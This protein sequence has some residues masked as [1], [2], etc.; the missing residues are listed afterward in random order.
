MI[1]DLDR[2]VEA[3]YAGRVVIVPTDTVYGIAARVDMP[4]AIDRIFEIKGRERAKALP[5]LGASRTQLDEVA[6]LDDRA[7]KLT[8]RYWP[9]A[10][11]L[12]LPRA[13]GF[14]TDLGGDGKTVAVRVPASETTRSLLE[15]S[16][17]LAVTSANRSGEPAAVTAED[18]RRALGDSVDV[19]LDTG[20]SAGTASTVVS[21]IAAPRL[22]RAGTVAW[23]DV[24]MTLEE[25]A[26][27]PGASP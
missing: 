19:F 5:V 15:R 14:T 4:G 12:V 17:P 3:L 9:G 6:A 18:A 2:A 22:L 25:G 11:T 7:G 23:S 13:P 20:P 1:A 24:Q 27:D 16:G 10:L 21:L 8:S 26:A